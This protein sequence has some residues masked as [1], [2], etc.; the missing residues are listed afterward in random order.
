M[1]AMDSLLLLKSFD[2]NQKIAM[3]INRKF[4]VIIRTVKSV[5]VNLFLTSL[6]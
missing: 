1:A 6:A 3:T 5:L 2:V 4:T